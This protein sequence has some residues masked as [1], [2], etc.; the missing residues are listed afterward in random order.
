MN[1]SIPMRV[2]TPGIL[3]LPKE[4]ALARKPVTSALVMIPNDFG[5]IASCRSCRI[6]GAAPRRA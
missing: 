6:D 2:T 5:A 4:R 1:N 3:A